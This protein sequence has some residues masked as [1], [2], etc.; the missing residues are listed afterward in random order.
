MDGHWHRRIGINVV[1][2]SS[3]PSFLFSLC[4]GAQPRRRKPAF[5]THDN[6]A[7]L[8]VSFTA[9]CGLPTTTCRWSYVSSLSA[10]SDTRNS[11]I[12]G[13]GRGGARRQWWGLGLRAWGRGN[14][15][16]DKVETQ[17]ETCCFKTTPTRHSH[18]GQDRDQSLAHHSAAQQKKK[19]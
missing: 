18:P 19:N 11:S 13:Q 4:L 2:R 17:E 6:A 1:A 7:S 10:D 15:G 14:T 9:N 12:V 8:C 5:V 3:S 16:P